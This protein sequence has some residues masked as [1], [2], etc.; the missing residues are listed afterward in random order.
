MAVTVGLSLYSYITSS[1]KLPVQLSMVTLTTP[2][3]VLLTSPERHVISSNA[4]LQSV[5]TQEFVTCRCDTTGDLRLN[6]AIFV[7]KSD[8]QR[9]SNVEIT[10]S[11]GYHGTTCLRTHPRADIIKIW[12]LEKNFQN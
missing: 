7:V 9:G 6:V 1:G 11:D 10:T 5:E 12:H 3:P 4:L 8:S 2:S